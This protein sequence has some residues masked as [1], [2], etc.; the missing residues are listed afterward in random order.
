MA[1]GKPNL[2]AAVKV[3]LEGGGAIATGS[4]SVCKAGVAKPCSRHPLLA[5]S[6]VPQIIFASNSFAPGALGV[7]L[8]FR[9]LP[10]W[11]EPAVF[12]LFFRAVVRLPAKPHGWRR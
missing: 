5:C 3:R 8:L 6:A 11:L 7:G 12:N 1:A 4:C 2:V 10:T 9:I